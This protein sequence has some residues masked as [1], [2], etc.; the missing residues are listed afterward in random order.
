M[1]FFENLFLNHIPLAVIAGDSIWY[2]RRPEKQVAPPPVPFT[3]APPKVPQLPLP[4][5]ND[6][7]SAF[8]HDRSR[9]HEELVAFVD[10]M[11]AEGCLPAG[12]PEK[13]EIWDAYQE[14]SGPEFFGGIVVQIL[15]ALYLNADDFVP[16]EYL[17]WREDVG[18][19]AAQYDKLFERMM[20]KPGTILA[21]VK[22]LREEV[23]FSKTGPE[24][25]T[26]SARQAFEL[27]NLK[28]LEIV[29]PV[30]WDAFLFVAVPRSNAKRWN[31][32]ALRATKGTDGK[33]D[34]YVR[35]ANFMA[36]HFI[37]DARPA[38]V[39]YF[40]DRTGDRPLTVTHYWEA[41]ECAVLR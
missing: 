29:P 13:W 7:L 41:S 18:N 40:K 3:V 12:A 14:G 36:S 2:F 39:D 19:A 1:S 24:V 35:D 21:N 17:D 32:R 15:S 4:D 28:L 22:A 30:G 16:L 34:I 6:R 33:H 37:E 31:Q 26:A 10:A 38:G 5:I 25:A 20:G 9:G 8:A 11:M 23:R 27:S